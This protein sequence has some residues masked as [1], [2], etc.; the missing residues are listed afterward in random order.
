MAMLQFT[1]DSVNGGEKEILTA[2]CCAAHYIFNCFVQGIDEDC[3]HKTG[4]EAGPYLAEKI[5]QMVA[6][7]FDVAC[8]NYPSIDVCESQHP[9]LMS[10]FHQLA[11]DGF[12]RQNFSILI[13]LMKIAHKIKYN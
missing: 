6:G 1:A 11:G 2:S 13:P 10:H 4:V 5:N 9:D 12:E 3:K 7:V 8:K